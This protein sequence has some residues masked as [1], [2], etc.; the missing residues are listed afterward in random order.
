MPDIV[1]Y[2][3]FE[4]KEGMKGGTEGGR[5][6]EKPWASLNQDPVKKQVPCWIFKQ[7]KFNTGD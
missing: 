3:F 6:E 7:R 1:L 4:K 5:Q 2:R